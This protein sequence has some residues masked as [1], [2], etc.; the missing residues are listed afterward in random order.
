MNDRNQDAKFVKWAKKVKQRDNYICQLCRKSGVSL[1]SHHINS[2]DVFISQR[3]DVNNGITLCEKC[4]NLFHD[5]YGRGKNTAY[6]FE[7]FK[8]FLKTLQ[9][10]AKKNIET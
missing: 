8:R 9:R 1:N 7:E 5:C 6:Q 4:H 3:Y 10:L 2:W